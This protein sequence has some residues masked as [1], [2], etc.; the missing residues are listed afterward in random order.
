MPPK[1]VPAVVNFMG[2]QFI[3]WEDIDN[4]FLRACL[5]EFL[6]MHLFVLLCCGC[7]MVTLNLPNPNLMMV[8]ASF[9]FGILT[10]A[11]IFGPLSGAHINSAVSLG[12]FVAGRTSLI[13]TLCY[14]LSQM[15]GS[16]FGALFLWAIFGNDWPAARAFGSNSWD[17]SV[18]N[19]G[20]VFFA[21]GLG[22]ALLMFNVLSTIDIPSEGGGPLGV[23][24]I[25][26][27]VMVAHLFLLPID[28]CSINPTRS[29]GPSL[30]AQWANISGNYYHQQSMF[31]FGPM[32]GAACAAF[33]YEYGSLKPENFAG[34]KDMDTALFQAN[35]RKKKRGSQVSKN[36]ALSHPAGEEVQN[37]LIT[38]ASRS[39]TMSSDINIS[40]PAAPGRKTA[41]APAPAPA[42]VPAPAPSPVRAAT[43]T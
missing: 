31:W 9:G 12:L 39:G 21:E 30:V 24:P 20:Q 25:A 6:A 34:A 4:K 43:P 22:T 32:F 13:K 26:M 16:V 3:I 33:F 8:A 1:N 18:F 11:Q 40:P 10:L 42:P 23:Y 41:P 15:L 27:S 38:S 17:E 28:G 19:G 14:T 29:F 7:A 36:N 5:A 37:V 2:R 35:K